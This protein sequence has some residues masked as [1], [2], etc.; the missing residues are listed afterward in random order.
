MRVRT[1]LGRKCVSFG[2]AC[3]AT[4]A[5]LLALG[6]G[7]LALAGCGGNLESDFNE[8]SATTGQALTAESALSGS[9]DAVRLRVMTFNIFYGGD[10]LDLT[11]G[12]FCPIPDGCN[13]TFERVVQTIRTA[14]ADVLGV[15]EPERNTARLAQELGW[16][17]DE[18]NH[19]ISKWPILDPPGGDGIYVFVQ[20]SPGKVVAMANVHL[21][22]DPY[23]PYLVRDGASAQELD[24]LER[25]TRLP[26][27]QDQLAKL[28]ALAA[29]GIPVFLTGDFN[30]PSHL[31]WT[32]AVARRRVDVKYPF[33]WPVS[34]ALAD[35]GLRDSYREVHTDPVRHPGFT[36]T[37]GGPES[38]PREVFDRIDWVLTAGPTTSALSQ[39]VGEAGGPDVE[40][41]VPAPFPSD[42]RAVVASFEAHAA[43]MPVLVAVSQRR[44]FVGDQ[45]TVTF[46]APGHGSERIA[47][48]RA[49]DCAPNHP[50][51][52][53]YGGTLSQSTG[54]AGTTDGALVF[55]TDRLRPGDYEARLLDADGKVLS[56]IPFW[57]YR[58]GEA[59]SVRVA[60][61]KYAVGETISVSWRA[62]P[63]RGLDWLGVYRCDADGCG[64]NTDYLLYT[65]T[66]AAIEGRA[67]I[68]PNAQVGG[69]SWPLEPGRYVVRLLTDDSYV[70][71]GTSDS[72]TIE[73]PRSPNTMN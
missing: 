33:V 27:I 69:A 41:A 20:V 38:D 64:A 49:N 62:A 34:K 42:H 46:H 8:A 25:Q 22:S 13:E 73:G 55:A 66:H 53:R 48:F 10:D 4:A 12:D 24:E 72:F 14:K 15:Q 43:E 2:G 47:L 45:L 16:Y 6:L 35:A 11:T 59:T 30:S 60:S 56:R 44:V 61:R 21:P 1:R 3:G 50:C 9:R 26:A 63:G 32:P 52:A 54:R 17:S 37:P 36:W 51:S 18:R 19:V 57:L 29:R 7:S 31:D 58:A 67:T 68:G 23:G 5:Q 71:L 70:D 39:L 28:P 40:I 65:Y